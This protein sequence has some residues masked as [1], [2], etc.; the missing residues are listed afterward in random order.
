MDSS[1]L[2]WIL[3]CKLNL[4]AHCNKLEEDYLKANI[5]RNELIERLK[6]YKM[7]EIEMINQ[8]NEVESE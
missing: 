8:S 3:L 4:Q 1:S 5:E 6:N 2:I 7:Q